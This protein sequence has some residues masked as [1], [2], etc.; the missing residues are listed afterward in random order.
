MLRPASIV[1]LLCIAGCGTNVGGS[2]GGGSSSSA[3]GSPRRNTS[4][5][6]AEALYTEDE[7]D[8]FLTGARLTR[9]DGGRATDFMNIGTSACPS[10]CENARSVNECTRACGLCI[11]AIADEVW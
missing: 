6:C 1:M 9:N 7:V 4:R 10:H 2:G 11:I 8:G 5:L 3:S